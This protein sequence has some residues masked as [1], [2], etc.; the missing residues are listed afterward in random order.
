MTPACSGGAG[1][2]LG[3][4]LAAGSK[5]GLLKVGWIESSGSTIGAVMVEAAES[6]YPC[7]RGCEAGTASKFS[8]FGTNFTGGLLALLV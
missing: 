5:P 7:E 4:M 6:L 8:G 2:P 3:I 1:T